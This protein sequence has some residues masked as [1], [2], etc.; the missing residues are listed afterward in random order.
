V[1]ITGIQLFVLSEATDRFFA[2]T[3]KPP[4][5]AAFLGAAYWASC[6]T[7]LLAARQR[8]WANARIAVPAVLVFTGL[9]LLVTLLHLDRF[10]LADPNP[11]ARA[12]AWAWLAVYAAVPPLMSI[13]LWRQLRNPGGDPPRRAPLQRWARGVL[14][15]HA[16]L[17]MPLGLALVIAPQ[18]LF[19]FWPW[20]LTPLTGRAIGAWLFALGIAAAHVIR[21]NDWVRVRAATPS[22]VIFGAL[23]LLALAR[24]PSDLS[25]DRPALWVMV[26]VLVSMLF[27]GVY[28][29]LQAGLA[30]HETSGAV[31][32]ESQQA[33]KG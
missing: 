5:T 14:A 22:Y 2:W 17:L 18:A 11:T 1:F 23:E 13:V 15:V 10:H 25:W 9:T 12:A 4:L 20:Q 27:G 31:R 19:D 29:W 26:A 16:A 8:I 24:Y 6:G 21:E 30:L 7:E 28:G 32:D 33:Q 3:I